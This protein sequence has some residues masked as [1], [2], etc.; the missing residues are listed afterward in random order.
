MSDMKEDP[1]A[2]LV[3]CFGIVIVLLSALSI[4]H[5]FLQEDARI[6]DVTLKNVSNEDL[7]YEIYVNGDFVQD[8]VIQPN[9]TATYQYVKPFGFWNKWEPNTVSIVTPNT[10]HE[11]VLAH[12]GDDLYFVLD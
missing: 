5:Y 11:K 10:V 7:P 8:G 6:M 12:V 1:L 4:A 3:M 9:G 2:T